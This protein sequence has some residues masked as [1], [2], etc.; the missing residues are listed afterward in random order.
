MAAIA[1][2]PKDA[3][4]ED[5]I[6]NQVEFYFSDSNLPRDKFLRSQTGEA[7]DG[8]V[9]LDI[10]AN[11]KRLKSLTTD[12]SVIRTALKTSQLVELNEDKTKLRRK[13]PL[14]PSISNK[15]KTIYV[16]GF[17]TEE[18]PQ[19][20][21]VV[22]LFSPYGVVRS[23]R[24]RRYPDTKKFKGSAFIEFETEEQAQRAAEEEFLKDQSGAELEV[25]TKDEYFKRKKQREQSTTASRGAQE[26][27]DSSEKENI[28]SQSKEASFQRGLILGLKNIGENVTREEIKQVFSS[29]GEISWIDFSRGQSTGY[30]RFSQPN[31]AKEAVRALQ[32]KPDLKD[33]FAEL[34]VLYG[35]EEKEY[36]SKVVQLQKE[37]REKSSKRK[38]NFQRQ[39]K[40]K[41]RKI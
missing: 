21:S 40:S 9:N 31:S 13:Y 26:E 37:K 3:S 4:L 23:V 41:R 14:P 16:K 5:K 38:K 11:F 24:F 29:F 2:A 35:D 10:V 33:K 20:E 7:G 19:L 15:R 34:W 22:E 1:A 8:Y 27:V 18:E 6:K 28:A 25:L 17:P 39:S 32:E 36:W 30:I 12:L